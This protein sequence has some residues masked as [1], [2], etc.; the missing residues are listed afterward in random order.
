LALFDYL[1][2]LEVLVATV[3]VCLLVMTLMPIVMSWVGGYYRYEDLGEV[4]NK[5][6]RIQ[7]AKLEGAGHRAY[8][9]QQ[10]CWEALGVFSAALLALLVAGVDPGSVATL[11][12]MVVVFRVVYCICYLVNQDIVRSLSF[13]AAF[14]VCMYLFYLAISAA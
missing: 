5:A 13:L 7:A 2:D 1:N 3:V 14:G 11:C 12:L 4:D 9:A 10:N 8:A 6:P